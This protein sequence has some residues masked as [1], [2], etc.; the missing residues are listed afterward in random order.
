ML[1]YFLIRFTNFDQ[2]FC[3]DRVISE[4]DITEHRFEN[5]FQ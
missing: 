3:D 4:I 1:N 2:I 5:N